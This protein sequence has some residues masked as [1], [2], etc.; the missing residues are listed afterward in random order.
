MRK[1]VIALL[2][3]LLSGSAATAAQLACEGVFGIDTSAARFIETF[4]KDDVVTGEVPGPEGTTMIATT[5][6]PGDPER[7]FQVVW[8]NETALTDLS[9][10]SVPAGNTAPGGVELGMSIEEVEA[11]NGGPFTMTG[12]WWDYGGSA[13]FQSGKLSELPNNCR[14]MI[15]FAPTVGLPAGVDSDP[16]AGDKEVSSDL[17]LLRRV[18]PE[19]VEILFGYPHPDFR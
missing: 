10:V 8:W 16:I 7:E 4:G 11:L 14:L 6:Y 5:V 9:Y 17:P 18:E 13:G 3:L 1:S 12:F 19:V 2:A 15:T